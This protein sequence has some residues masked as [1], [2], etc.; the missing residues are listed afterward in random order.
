MLSNKLL[1]FIVFLHCK[2]RNHQA[3]NEVDRSD[4]V[5]EDDNGPPAGELGPEPRLPNGGLN[6]ALDEAAMVPPV[7]LA[8]A[9]D[10]NEDPESN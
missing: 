8:D 6:R 10:D 3:H 5:G 9:E 4:E 2:Q 7:A 1:N